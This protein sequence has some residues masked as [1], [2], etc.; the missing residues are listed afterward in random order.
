MMER[1]SGQVVLISSMA[2]FRG[3]PYPPAYSVSKV[4]VKAYGDAIRLG[5]KQNGVYVSTVFPGFIKTPLT[6]VNKFAMPF[7]MEVDQAA[8]IIKKGVEERKIYIAFPWQMHLISKA[9]SLLPVSIGDFLLSL[10]P[11]K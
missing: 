10:A 8:S 6:Q 9:I 11:S 2:G 1:K 7:L 4:A 3:L 5:A